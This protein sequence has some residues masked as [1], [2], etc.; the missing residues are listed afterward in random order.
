MFCACTKLCSHLTHTVLGCSK[1]HAQFM[2]SEWGSFSGFCICMACSAATCSDGEICGSLLLRWQRP[3]HVRCVVNVLLQVC[4]AW[5]S[6]QHMGKC[7]TATVQY[8]PSYST[9]L[10]CDSCSDFYQAK[11]RLTDE[12]DEWNKQYDWPPDPAW[13][14]SDWPYGVPD[15]QLYLH[16]AGSVEVA[17]LIA[18]LLV[19]AGVAAATYAAKV[20]FHKHKS[21]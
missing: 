4:A 16:E 21:S 10:V 18:G 3:C 1:H 5:R 11:W 12:A 6:N 15:L 2:Q 17:V 9:R 13:T 14:E 8:V 20:A 7:V 19:T